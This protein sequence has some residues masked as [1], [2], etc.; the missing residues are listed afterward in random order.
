ML[1][2]LRHACSAI[3]S[4]ARSPLYSLTT[5]T[6]WPSWRRMCAQRAVVAPFPDRDDERTGVIITILMIEN[7]IARPT[8]GASAD[9]LAAQLR[10]TRT[11]TSLL[12]ED[13]SNR[14]LMG[15]MLPI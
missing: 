2:A 14:Q 11:R 12:T 4:S 10:D 9:E 8:S 5:S 13:L 3:I 6:V 7:L 1:P 15:P